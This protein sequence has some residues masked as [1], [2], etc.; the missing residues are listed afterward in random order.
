MK[1]GSRN[2]RR[3]EPDVYMWRY[4]D[5]QWV[6]LRHLAWATRAWCVHC[7]FTSQSFFLFILLYF[8]ALVI[9][10]HTHLVVH[11]LRALLIYN[12]FD[13]AQYFG[14]L[15]SPGLLNSP[16]Q[17]ESFPFLISGSRING[18]GYRLQ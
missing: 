8:V 6:A 17:I 18:T 7:F 14:V 11:I 12:L 2:A 5:T 16:D 15:P 10:I 9:C 3:S 13:I 4:E 1:T